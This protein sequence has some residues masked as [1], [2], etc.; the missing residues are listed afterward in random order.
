[1][2][3][4]L[5]LEPVA[6]PTSAAEVYDHLTA[7]AGLPRDD[8][9]ETS[10]A[11]LSTPRLV[12]RGPAL[13]QVRERLS[14]LREGQAG[15]VA[16]AAAAG[17]G[18]SR[19][20]D[21]CIL[22]AKLAG[23][24][25]VRADG[26]DAA[27]GPYGVL[28]ALTRGLEGIRASDPGEADALAMLAADP[29][30]ADLDARRRPELQRAFRARLGTCAQARPLLVA[31]DDIER[32]DEA[33]LAALALT[34]A[35]LPQH[36]LIAVCCLTD[37]HARAKGPLDLL[38]Q[39]AATITLSPHGLADTEALLRSIFGDGPYLDTLT[40]R[41]HERA[42]GSP[43]GCMELSQYLLDHGLVRYDRG[44]WVVPPSIA[45]V[46]LP[47]T[48]SVA[49][50]E[51][52][53][54]LT[55]DARELGEAMALSEGTGLDLEAFPE[56]TTHGDVQRLHA[57]L[58]E[59]L[60][61]QIVR[62]EN[63]NYVFVSLQL[64]EE[65]EAGVAA[66]ARSRFC[67]RIA[68][69]LAR[70]ARDRL[71]VAGYR[72]R[73]GQHGPAIDLL[74]EELSVGSR[75]NRAP[76]NYSELLREALEAAEALHR[77]RRDLM[78]LRHELVKVSQDLGASD[79]R[80][81][82]IE[83][84]AELRHD[85][86]LDL[87]RTHQWPADPQTRMQQLLERAQAQH[88]AQSAQQRGFAPIEAIVTLGKLI[89]ET[90]AL[91]ARTSDVE[92]LEFIPRL[93]P[94]YPLSRSLQRIDE[95]T[96]P[97]CRAIIAGQY[98]QAGDLYE[99]QLAEVQAADKAQLPADL[100][101][102]AIRALHYGLG[103]LDASLGRQRAL[104]HAA[105]I[106]QVPG[107]RVP[108]YSIRQVYHLTLGSLKE[109]DRYRKRI[110][111]ARLESS[112]KP[113][114]AAG[115]VCQHVFVLS[116]CDNANGMREAITELEALCGSFPS[117]LPFLLF[118]RADHAR[119]CGNYEEAL[120]WIDQA[121]ERVQVAKHP[122]W[123]WL[124]RSCL[125]VLLAQGRYED[126]RAMGVQELSRWEEQEMPPLRGYLDVSLATAEARLGSFDSA[127]QRLDHAI[128]VQRGLG[129]RGTAVTMVHETRARVAIWM[130][131]VDAFNRHTA[132]CA[133]QLAMCRGEPALAARYQ[134]LVR[135]AR[136]HGL[137][138]KSELAGSIVST[139]QAEPGYEERQRHR[140]R[141]RKALAGCQH[142]QERFRQALALIVN[143][144]GALQAELFVVEGDG[145]AC[146]AHTAAGPSQ[147]L[148]AALT[149][150]LGQHAC[151]HES[152]RTVTLA[153]HDPVTLDGVL[154]ER[155]PLPLIDRTLE[156]PHLVGV[157]VLYFDASTLVRLPRELAGE[158]AE[159]LSEPD[160]APTEVACEPDTRP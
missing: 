76:P 83:L 53:A 19:M 31:V 9:R 135:E 49:R 115:A 43:S 45:N 16:I 36:I 146:A 34:A 107:W 157:A 125:E 128:Q 56:L 17:L 44:R 81:R 109:A 18:R 37:A 14:R 29:L 111:L 131:D 1:M 144:C 12:A 60:L 59:L 70:R 57:A 126:A 132:V 50:Q 117:M 133:Q 65:L 28:A 91:A 32:C 110:E 106:E 143:S 22:E 151:P 2:L 27:H 13:K 69:S 15:V 153:M 64:C 122:L 140:R 85:S 40:M 123:P 160:E 105:A 75:W 38:L 89:A 99:R 156:E 33:S 10:A 121:R 77:P 90:A 23:M 137:P 101:Q 155:W 95:A 129:L 61:A 24:A 47:K 25:A 73:A 82:T 149:C 68:D 41:V 8:Q 124:V 103:N 72:H 55:V 62:Q 159:A 104:E 142:K 141:V 7:I 21:H 88:D 42:E 114:L 102:W 130:N 148:E 112:V 127:C 71:E 3:G 78:V 96:I 26:S 5:N 93:E 20:L 80:E 46:R 58:D 52:L 94:Y 100:K 150:M 79:L 51:K 67:S 118:A 145:L 108:A 35:Y 92:L 139:A 136:D 66:S 158:V 113:P 30:P 119:I 120:V 87:W 39:D 86:G 4:L 97:S 98:E 74:L 134:Q 48:L 116:V 152:E 84:L 54:S 147:G 154:T 6:R 63:G 11:Y 138:F